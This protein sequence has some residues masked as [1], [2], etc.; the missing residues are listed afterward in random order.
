[1]VKHRKAP[2]AG[3]REGIA[4]RAPADA[5]HPEQLAGLF[6]SLQATPT[7]SEAGRALLIEIGQRARG[8][9]WGL[10]AIIAAV[11]EAADEQVGRAYSELYAARF[12][13]IKAAHGLTGGERFIEGQEPEEY[14]RLRQEFVDFGYQTFAQL[15]RLHSEPDLADLVER[16]LPAFQALRETARRVLVHATMS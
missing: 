1:M 13:A 8:T 15:F 4:R 7:G 2:R 14:R 12:Q 11:E 9:P 3:R 6:A 5:K 16:D 10:L